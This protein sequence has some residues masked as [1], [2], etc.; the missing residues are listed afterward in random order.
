MSGCGQINTGA[1]DEP[2]RSEDLDGQIGLWI[3]S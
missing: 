3:K 1:Q 2:R